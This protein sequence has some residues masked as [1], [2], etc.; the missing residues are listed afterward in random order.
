M[1]SPGSTLQ[2]SIDNNLRTP[3]GNGVVVSPHRI[4]VLLDYNTFAQLEQ[5]EISAMK[6][7]LENVAR[8]HITNRRYSTES[9]VT[10]N[11]TY[12]PLVATPIIRADFGQTQAF[13]KVSDSSSTSERLGFTPSGRLALRLKST[14]SRF[15][16]DQTMNKL[17]PGGGPM[18]VGRGRD[19]NIV[20][21]DKSVSKFHSTIALT[22]DGK[23][24]VADV[25]SSN[26]TFV[27]NKH[28]KGREVIDLET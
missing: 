16:L 19:N 22:K 1:Q 3:D 28:I 10:L 13:S 12:D 9:N 7:E 18:T 26:G 24:I 14:N 20:I 8:E 27:N 6:Q 4:V 23:L 15:S 2:K 17:K 5:S 11:I 25:G 21:D